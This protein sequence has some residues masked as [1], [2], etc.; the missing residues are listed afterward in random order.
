MPVR[1][2]VEKRAPESAPAPVFFSLR[3]RI[4]ARDLV[5]A[6]QEFAGQGSGADA[7]LERDFAVDDRVAVLHY[8]H[9]RTASTARSFAASMPYRLP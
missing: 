2:K 6:A 5:V 1:E 7:V 9:R 8:I 4:S 3:T